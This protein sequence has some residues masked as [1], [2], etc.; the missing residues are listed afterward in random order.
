MY[1]QFNI[2]IQ[3][4]LYQ[5]SV[6][7]LMYLDMVIYQYIICIS[8]ARMMHP[9]LIFLPE[10]PAVLLPLLAQLRI[11]DTSVVPVEQTSPL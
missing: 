11:A 10:Q 8:T 5:Y 1:P 4:N 6:T 9:Q 7:G 3:L 2:S